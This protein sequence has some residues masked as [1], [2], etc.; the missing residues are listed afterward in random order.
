MNYTVDKNHY[1]WKLYQDTCSMSK[2]ERDLIRNNIEE[3]CQWPGYEL[4]KMPNFFEYLKK[5]YPEI[6]KSINTS[7]LVDLGSG[8]GHSLYNFKKNINLKI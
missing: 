5:N 3:H 1:A 4:P 6:N 7:T 8:Y 2:K